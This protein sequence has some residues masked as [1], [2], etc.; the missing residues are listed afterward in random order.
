MY[1]IDGEVTFDDYS[2]EID[3]DYIFNDFDVVEQN[4]YEEQQT[5]NDNTDIQFE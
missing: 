1:S 2:V 4:I 3:S 5:I